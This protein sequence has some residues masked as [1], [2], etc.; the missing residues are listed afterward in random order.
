MSP[1]QRVHYRLPASRSLLSWIL[2]GGFIAAT[3]DILYAT[4]FSALKGVPPE[5]VLQFIASGALGKASFSGGVTT[6]ALGLAFHY[7]IALMMASTYFLAARRWPL[8]VQRPWQCGPAYGLLLYAVME[9]V[10]VPLSAA[11]D[12]RTPSLL[13][14][15]CSIVVHMFLVGLPIALC[16]RRA[17]TTTTRLHDDTQ[18][19]ADAH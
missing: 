17:L 10:V 14:I 6:A 4:G 16:A 13:S 5:R 7:L 11:P 9:G 19:A 12:G 18:L 3:F 8:L 2:I 1:Q 15:A